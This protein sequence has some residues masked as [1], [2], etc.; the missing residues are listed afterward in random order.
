MIL[1]WFKSHR[2]YN[3]NW[4]FSKTPLFLVQFFRV[5]P[6]GE[7]IYLLWK[8]LYY[9]LSPPCL[10]LGWNQHIW[11]VE[12]KNRKPHCNIHFKLVRND[13]G[14]HCFSKI[15]DGCS[16][17][18]VRLRRKYEAKYFLFF[19]FFCITEEIC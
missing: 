7:K 14:F 5:F 6:V 2:Q 12:K 9:R 16:E 18:K 1:R 4:Q 8:I 11:A 17:K 15:K 19:F 13:D 10:G 3:R